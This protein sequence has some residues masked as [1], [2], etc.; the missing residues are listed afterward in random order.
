AGEDLRLDQQ[1]P[2]RRDPRPQR[3]V[4]YRQRGTACPV[5][6][7]RTAPAVA[8]QMHDDRAPRITHPP[9]P[10]D[11]GHELR[12]GTETLISIPPRVRGGGDCPFDPPESRPRDT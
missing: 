11:D 10:G 2:R 12:G 6:T 4:L 5:R 9:G 1:S 3:G 7:H 8:D